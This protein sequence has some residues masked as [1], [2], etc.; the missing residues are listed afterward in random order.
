[1]NTSALVL[2]WGWALWIA[3]LGAIS[4]L[5]EQ[6]YIFDW[7]AGVSAWAIIAAWLAIGYRPDELKEI[8]LRTKLLS[9]AFDLSWQKG[10]LLTGRKVRSIL[11]TIFGQKTFQDV[12][13]PLV[14]SATNYETGNRLEITHGLIIDAV[15]ASLSIPLL[16]TPFYHPEYSCYCVDGGLSH[17]FPVDL[18]TQYYT[19]NKIVGI[20]VCT[21][22]PT[23]SRTENSIQKL[24][25]PETMQRVLKIFFRNQQL[26]DDKR[27]TLIRPNLAE[28]TSFD[29]FRLEE[30]WK[31][32][33]CAFISPEK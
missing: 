25:L 8:I 13:F 14:I 29:I 9:L 16:F 30:M 3:H 28:F 7:Y 31:V 19:G 12:H 32:G 5:D 18:A 26:P 4:A 6:W 22:L 2:S 10:W 20:D 23:L 17:N 24:S 11:E 33:Y 21:S 27:V 15:E 1:M